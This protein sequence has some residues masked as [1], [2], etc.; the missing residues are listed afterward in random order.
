MGSAYDVFD[1][2]TSEADDMEAL[3]IATK[4][5]TDALNQLGDFEWTAMTMRMQSNANDNEL[6]GLL[7]KDGV[8]HFSAAI[9]THITDR[10]GGGDAFAAGII[11]GIARKWKPEQTVNF[12]TAA[13]AATQT[14][15]GDINYLT[16]QELLQIASGSVKGQVQ[17]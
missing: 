2:A 9:P 13:F 12:A 15:Q 1:V 6:A 14:L 8:Y 3:K 10:L 17:R 7:V 5:A 4:E 16:E 11:H